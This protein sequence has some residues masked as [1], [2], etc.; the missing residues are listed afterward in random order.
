MQSLEKLN[1]DDVR[2]LL[3]DEPHAILAPSV[4]IHMT[5]FKNARILA[6]GATMDGRFDDSD[7]ILE[8][9]VGPI[10]YE[11]SFRQAVDEKAICD[12]RVYMLRVPFEPFQCN[13]RDQAYNRLLLK[14]NAFNALVKRLSAEV[15]PSDWQTLIFAD[16]VKQIELMN[17]F[18]EDGVPAI[19]SQMTNK[20]RKERFAMMK[21]GEIKRCI[22]TDIYSQGVTFPDLR[23][24]IN[25]S[26]G[27]G[28][29]TGTQKPG[30]LAQRRPGKTRGYLIDFLFQPPGMASDEEWVKSAQKW[31][32]VVQDCQAR[33]KVYRANGYD[34]RVINNIE[35]IEL[36]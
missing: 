30:R 16:L 29:I 34:V 21:T 25:A 28:S 31:F 6:Y 18:V 4:L 19:A 36:T 24:I 17:Q 20:E 9:L 32:Y 26:G 35:E 15:I 33:M 7:I 22:C 5:K 3:I 13:T 27:G 11:K 8:G 12:I 14:N 2:L 1:P 23:C 10:L